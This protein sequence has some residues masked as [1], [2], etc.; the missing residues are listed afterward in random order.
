[1][2]EPFITRVLDSL[3]LDYRLL[4]PGFGADILVL[5]WMEFVE[6]KNPNLPPSSRKLTDKEQELKQLCEYLG[7]GYYV[8]E[9]PQEM[10]DIAG[11]HL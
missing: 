4:P 9:Q 1:M 2:N 11:K 8:V 3:Q 6:V 7:V 5:D 10:A